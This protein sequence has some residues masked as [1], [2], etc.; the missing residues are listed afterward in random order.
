MGKRPKVGRWLKHRAKGICVCGIFVS[1]G[2]TAK[3]RNQR[4][5]LYFNK[6]LQTF[7]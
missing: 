3:G 2:E 5:D 1:L 7:A 4:L 6:K